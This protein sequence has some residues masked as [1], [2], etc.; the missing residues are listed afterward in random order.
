MHPRLIEILK[1]E[2]LPDHNECLHD[3]KGYAAPVWGDPRDW[4]CNCYEDFLFEEGFKA[5]RK[6]QSESK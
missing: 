5:G 4:L 3:P 1:N 6:Q 2:E